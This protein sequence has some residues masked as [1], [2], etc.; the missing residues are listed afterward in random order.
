MKTLL[1]LLILIISSH[2]SNEIINKFP[3][4]RATPNQFVCLQLQEIIKPAIIL[5][6][7]IYNPN[8]NKQAKG[9]ITVTGTIKIWRN[10]FYY[11]TSTTQIQNITNFP[12]E[13]FD[14]KLFSEIVTDC[15]EID[16]EDNW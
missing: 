6:Y 4:D 8:N 1:W 14:F 2:A 12:N 10:R 15:F 16:L 13:L 3:F 9:F 11:E 5:H 7:S